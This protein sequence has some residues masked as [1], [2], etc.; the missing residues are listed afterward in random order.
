VWETVARYAEVYYGSSTGTAASEAKFEAPFSFQ[1]P[2]ATAGQNLILSAQRFSFQTATATPDPGGDPLT[3]PIAGSVE[4][5]A[6]G[7]I[8]TAV[9]NNA[10]A[11]YPTGT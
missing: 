6:S 5:P 10:V 11:T 3:V 4:R 2:H 8:A 1:F 9:V 7:S